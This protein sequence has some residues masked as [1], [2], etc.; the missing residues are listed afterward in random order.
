LKHLLTES[1]NPLVSKLITEKVVSSDGALRVKFRGPAQKENEV[2]QNNRLY[3]TAIWE[4]TLRPDSP[5]M[6]KIDNRSGLGELEH[7]DSGNTHLGRVSRIIEKVWREPLQDNNDYGVP[8]GDYIM[9]EGTTLNTPMGN[10]ESELLLMNIPVGQSS[11]GRGDTVN[12]GGVE[13]VQEDYDL[14]IFDAVYQ[15]SVSTAYATRVV[16][17]KD[18]KVKPL[19]KLKDLKACESLVEFVEKFAGAEEGL[20]KTNKSLS[21]KVEEKFLQLEN[22]VM[23]TIKI[24]RPHTL[25]EAVDMDE[26]AAQ[27]A[28]DRKDEKGRDVFKGEV[29]SNLKKYGH[30]VDDTTVKSLA[31][32]LRGKGFTVKDTEYENTQPS[33]GNIMT[34]IV[35]KTK[36]KKEISVEDMVAKVMER[37]NKLKAKVEKMEKTQTISDKDTLQKSVDASVAMIEGLKKLTLS[38]RAAKKVL[39]KKLKLAKALFARLVEKV[40]KGQVGT[41]RRRTRTTRPSARKPVGRRV[42]ESKR[43]GKT[44]G[45]RLNESKRVRR[46]SNAPRVGRRRVSAVT[47]ESLKKM[48][49]IIGEGV[50]P[51]KSKD[52][53]ENIF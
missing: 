35:N 36:S 10:I 14:D 42:S 48:R 31:N 49:K 43:V 39:E 27:I 11:R 4:R 19:P 30:T 34:K 6:Q 45:R 15:P 32:S 18:R 50:T 52:Y 21:K 29:E 40:K 16:E 9:V 28:Q 51:S 33:R 37:H 13:M 8:K 53:L 20:K 38:E 46:P 26:L 17:S 47:T 3:P 7:P 12:E 25:K 2:N 23:D 44:L 1:D 24:T 41:S 5:F 22:L